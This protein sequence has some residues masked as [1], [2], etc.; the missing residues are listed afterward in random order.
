MKLIDA[1][2]LMND[3]KVASGIV[4]RKGGIYD[5]TIVGNRTI[6]SKLS[7]QQ[8]KGKWIDDGTELGCCCSKCGVTLDDYFYGSLHEICLSKIPNYCPSCGADMRKGEEK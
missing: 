3:I 2:K 7:Q 1:D 4:F 8:K 5:V 6:I